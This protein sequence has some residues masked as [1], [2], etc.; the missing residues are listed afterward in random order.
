[1]L[2]FL[3]LLLSDGDIGSN[4]IAISVN[5]VAGEF[6]LVNKGNGCQNGDRVATDSRDSDVG[7]DFA[8]ILGRQNNGRQ[9]AVDDVALGLGATAFIAC[10][11]GES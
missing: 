4:E 3:G 1:M 6:G 7:R 11:P 9:G 10:I 2:E 5:V 8:G